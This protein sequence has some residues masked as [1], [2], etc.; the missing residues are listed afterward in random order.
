V[1]RRGADFRALRD[2]TG[3]M[4]LDG[5]TATLD[6]VT[7]ERRWVQEQSGQR[8]QRWCLVVRASHAPGRPLW[9]RLE[10]SLRR[11]GQ[12]HRF[13]ASAGRY[14]GLFWFRGLE[15]PEALQ[16]QL[17]DNLSA[18]Q[19]ISVGAFKKEAEE[20]QLFADF[21]DLSTPSVQ[22]SGPRPVLAEEPGR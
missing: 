5:E 13:H 7:V 22:S 20:R 16:E 3:E 1:L 10:T 15:T 4:R 6:G 17:N 2:L 21:N 14:V 8:E 18:L 9:A 12:E 11:A 19:L